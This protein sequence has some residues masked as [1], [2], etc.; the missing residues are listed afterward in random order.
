MYVANNL[1][2]FPKFKFNFVSFFKIGAFSAGG[3][4]SNLSLERWG[5]IVSFRRPVY[6]P[7]DL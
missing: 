5:G 4:I 1:V 7:P 2:Y 6:C 3:E